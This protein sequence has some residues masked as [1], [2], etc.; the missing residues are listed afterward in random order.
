MSTPAKNIGRGMARVDGAD[1]VR[2]LARYVDDLDIPGCW[3]GA[4]VRSP[5]S[6]GRLC[7]LKPDPAFDWSQ[8]VV[9]TPADIPGPN[10]LVMHD[11]SMPLL[12]FDE[13]LY[14]GE[15]L[16][17]VAAPTRRLAREAAARMHPEIEEL[18]PV[19][20]TRELVE[21]FKANSPALIRLAA[22]TIVK[23]DVAAGLAAADLVVE[24]EYAA[25][26]QEQLYIEPQGL[27][28]IPQPDGGVFIQGSLQCPFFV[29][30]ELHEALNLPAEKVRVTQAAVGG[31][32]GGKE[33]FPTMLAGYCALPALKSGHPVKMVF[34]R[35]EDIL[36]STKRH[37]VWARYV[38]G[39]KK[40]GTITA[41]KVDFMLDGGAYLTLS[42]VVLY[43][44]VLHA[45]MGYR[46][47]NVFINGLVGR[48]HT[49]P[50]GAFRG[51]GAPQGVLGI[52]CH[53][54]RMA[55][56]CGMTP[57]AFRLKNCLRQGDTTPTG[58]VLRDSVG[59][60]AVLETAL[61]RSDFARKF[62]RCSRGRPGSK[63]W[64]GI[65][66]SF[67]AH[68][69]GFTGDG[70]ARIQGR[71]ALEL[72]YLADGRPGVLIRVSSTEMGQG[73]LTV[74]T[75][76]VADGLD[77]RP[78]RVAYPFADTARV[79]NSGPTVASRTTMVVGSTLYQVARA[80]QQKLLETPTGR[81][82]SFRN[83]FEAVAG[84]YLQAHGPLR[85]EEQF[86]LPDTIQ[87]D[88]KTFRGDSYPAY[89]WGCNI[90]ELD[91]DPL[92]F[93][94]RVRKV[95]ACYD[96]GRV[97]NPVLASGQVEGGLTQALGYAL[98]EKIGIRNG[99][100]DADRLQTYIIPTAL[101][102]PAYDVCFVEF[103]YE[104]AAP[105]A[106]GLGEIPM[107]G[108]APAV[109]NA[110]KQAT[111]LRFT[112]IPVMPEAIWEAVTRGERK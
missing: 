13:I 103:P 46:C 30:H 1:K 69:A 3:H 53:V 76:I 86:R 106:K 92:T 73:A 8:V 43:R 28:A 32:F 22:Q 80:M 88:Q 105:G 24:G 51:F 48:T 50:C 20:T 77:I 35:H 94:V 99:R 36:F 102:V 12:A 14:L 96:I 31:A 93:A 18:P 108:M 29:S 59:S 10:V 97:I 26:Y 83:R 58:Q 87:W 21:Q 23:G 52:E 27:V 70:E 55:E 34:D 62:K 47:A 107:D 41:L 42:D 84:A 101:D 4:M 17:V 19:L 71:S 91:V 6:H 39:L 79:P 74:L 72:D 82:G 38:A 11:R 9:A 7:G 109:L 63:K 56:A 33:D 25:G 67:F 5:V 85:M 78:A 110:L 37:P 54:D 104:F 89:S 81:R 95:T 98:M 64:Y 15:P 57:D 60:P 61:R 90:V 49:F 40:D 66:I 111:G 2:G 65:G 75:Q 68:G 44:G 16:A 100:Y 45:G 112:E